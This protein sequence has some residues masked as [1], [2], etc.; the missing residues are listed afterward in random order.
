MSGSDELEIVESV[1]HQAE[2]PL[3][4]GRQDDESPARQRQNPVEKHIS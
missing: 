2:R 1:P 4:L 3:A